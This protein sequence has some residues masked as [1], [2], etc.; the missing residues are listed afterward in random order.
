[1]P[2][3]TLF[4]KNWIYNTDLTRKVLDNI[5]TV[6]WR[7]LYFRGEV[8]QGVFD[9]LTKGT[10]EAHDEQIRKILKDNS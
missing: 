4:R 10:L 3:V 1:M 2:E 7:E 5:D 8:S 6:D 9:I